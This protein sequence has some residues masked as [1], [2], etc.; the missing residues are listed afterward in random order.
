MTWLTIAGYLLCY[1]SIADLL[2]ETATGNGATSTNPNITEI[3][4]KLPRSSH[5]LLRANTTA[6]DNTGL[7]TSTTNTP[8]PAIDEK[9]K[10]AASTSNP[11]TL[12]SPTVYSKATNNVL[13]VNNVTGKIF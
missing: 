10:L 3:S 4:N 8:L 6:K 2:V 5:P 7:S 13:D 9:P 12:T 1:A 11:T